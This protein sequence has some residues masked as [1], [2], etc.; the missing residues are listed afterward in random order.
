MEQP[1][2]ASI[3]T[4]NITN[5]G[6]IKARSLLPRDIGNMCWYVA[7]EKDFVGVLLTSF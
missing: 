7:G 3:T 5:E 2:D 1:G 4:L 6:A